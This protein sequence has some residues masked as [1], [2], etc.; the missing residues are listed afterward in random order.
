M[1]SI[2]PASSTLSRGGLTGY[3]LTSAVQ[4]DL[5]SN[6]GY[7]E[8]RWDARQE[9]ASVNEIREAIECIANDPRASQPVT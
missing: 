6:W 9:D 1:P 5:S 8:D 7:T 2:S 3:R 4:R